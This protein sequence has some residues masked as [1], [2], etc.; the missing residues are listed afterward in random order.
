MTSRDSLHSHS[1]LTVNSGSSS[2]KFALFTLELEPRRLLGG[3]VDRI[4]SSQ[5]TLAFTELAGQSSAPVPIDAGCH[6]I[7]AERLIDWLVPHTR[8]TS[9]TAVGHR[10]V[11]GGPLYGLPQELTS[12]V[13]EDLRR[14]VPFARNHLSAE[15]ALI[16]A[17]RHGRPNLTQVACFRHGVSSRSS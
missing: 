2:L 10:I 7:A 11:H 3:M 5:A 1:V 16:D 17:F 14:L 12:H 9:L 4:G 15:L 6:R 8:D 13:V